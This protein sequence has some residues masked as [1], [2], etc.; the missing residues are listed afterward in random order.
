VTAGLRV[1]EAKVIVI[2]KVGEPRSPFASQLPVCQRDLWE[3]STW[4][5]AIVVTRSIDRKRR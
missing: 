3:G 5:V 1:G 4:T 2:E